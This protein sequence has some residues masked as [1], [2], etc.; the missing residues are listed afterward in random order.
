MR[1]EYGPLIG[2]VESSDTGPRTL[3]PPLAPVSE[4]PSNPMLRCSRQLGMLVVIGRA[5]FAPENTSRMFFVVRC[6]R[7]S[8]HPFGIGG[9]EDGVDR[10]RPQA[11]DIVP[12]AKTHAP[13]G[14]W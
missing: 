9:S 14:A 1:I 7:A 5:A 12:L 4:P 3:S 2:A 13:L 10:S 6:I 11:H 8:T